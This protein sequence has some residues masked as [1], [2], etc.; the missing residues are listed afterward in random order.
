MKWNL[1]VTIDKKDSFKPIAHED[2][3]LSFGSC[4][5]EHIAN[6]LEF[7]GWRVSGNPFGIL[8][9]P[10]SIGT[11][12]RN[13]LSGKEYRV[14]DLIR[15][16][17]L[18]LSTDHHTSFSDPDPQI[19][20]DRINS[21]LGQARDYLGKASTL[22][23][24]F[25][26]AYYF[27]SK[28]NGNIVG[29]NHKI[30]SSQFERSRAS[31]SSITGSYTELLRQLMAFNNQMQIIFTVSP[32][33]H[34]K[35]GA[36]DDHWSKAILTCAVRELTETFDQA[37]YFPSYEILMDELRDHRFYEAD[38][39]HPNRQAV[40]YI[41]QTFEDTCIDENARK[42]SEEIVGLRQRISHKILKPTD[43]R[44]VQFLE[45]TQRIATR[46]TERYPYL[47]L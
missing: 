3:L 8:Y 22:I 43:P 13:I 44:S 20:L 39:V 46:I 15:Y 31:I 12:L 7:R 27:T 25:G 6:A 42:I 41:W 32:V 36:A 18:W 24:T 38:L 4:F 45:E 2:H 37:H 30:P 26:T 16:E 19:A 9:N 14:S 35:N 23:I 34:W 5:S 21:S 47:D 17:G 33:R 10:F 40:E 11:A 29:N 1:Q 28:E